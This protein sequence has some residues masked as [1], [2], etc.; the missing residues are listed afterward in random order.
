LKS[1]QLHQPKA[2]AFSFPNFM[3]GL[4]V[5]AVAGI[6]LAGMLGQTQQARPAE[7][8]AVKTATTP[9][10]QRMEPP[11]P[12]TPIPQP[13]PLEAKADSATE[14]DLLNILRETETPTRDE[15]MAAFLSAITPT[16]AADLR[17]AVKKLLVARK[18]PPDYEPI[19]NRRLGQLIGPEI[20]GKRTGATQ[21]EKDG[22]ATYI[23][24]QF[25]GWMDVD[26]VAAQAWLDGLQNTIFK[27]T[28]KTAYS[29][30]K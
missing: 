19:C 3:I 23:K 2:M 11:K 4:V 18:M 27:V 6:I 30:E 17:K 14:A 22:A 16:V 24:D 12:A 13:S 28:L 26:P 8:I 10:V 21:I 1:K 9:V 20:V 5:G 25:A 7:P 15:K 29:E